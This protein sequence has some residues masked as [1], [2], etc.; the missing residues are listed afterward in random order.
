M[1]QFSSKTNIKE[2]TDYNSSNIKAQLTLELKK[3]F[4]QII[5]SSLS[6][7]KV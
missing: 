4:N 1:N 7:I 3:N 5:N 6:S 2:D